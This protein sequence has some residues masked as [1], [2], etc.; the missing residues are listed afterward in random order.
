M[1][2]IQ[3]L[4]YGL[5]L[6][7]LVTA[8]TGS[9]QA[10]NGSHPEGE[11]HADK[12][13]AVSSTATNTPGLDDKR[14]RAEA[15]RKIS[16]IKEEIREKQQKN[17]DQ[18]RIKRCEVKEANAKKRF[19]AIKTK[20]A[21]VKSAIDTILARV[22]NFKA[23]KNITIK[24]EEA[25]KTDIVTKSQAVDDAVASI[26][27]TAAGFSCQNDDAAE[28]VALIKSQVDVY[29]AAIKAYRQSVKAYFQAILQALE[30]KETSSSNAS[31]SVTLSVSPSVSPQGDSQ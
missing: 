25:L 21:N 30:G 5:C 8:F 15:L 6:V 4:G 24:N 11:G 28:Q 27:A 31:P 3:R 18:Q 1:K 13:T 12:S 9:V 23:K 26:K 7:L 10:H 2:Y 17:K 20:T 16:V 19:E 14:G 22:E 29:K